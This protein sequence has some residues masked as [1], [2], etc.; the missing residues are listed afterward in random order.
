MAG[1]IDLFAAGF[2]ATLLGTMA[3]ALGGVAAL[4]YLLIRDALPFPSGQS[5]GKKLMKLRAVDAEGKPLAGNWWGSIQRNLPLV[6]VIDIV[7]LYL[8]RDRDGELLRLGDE[9]AGTRVVAE[10]EPPLS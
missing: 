4:A 1:I 5:L 3:D 6:L 2:I 8:R 9:W 10:G 7:V